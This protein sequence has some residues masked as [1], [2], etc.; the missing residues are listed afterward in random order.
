MTDS[1]VSA[2]AAAAAALRVHRFANGVT[3]ILWPEPR[4]TVV[5]VQIWVGT[6]SADEVAG[7][8]G[9]AHMLEHLMFRGTSNVPDGE[10]DRRMEALGASINAATWL[11]YTAYTATAPPEALAGILALEAD[12]FDGLSLSPAVFTA[13]RSVV[14]NE[15][16]QVVEADPIARLH[17]TLFARTL[18]GSNYA[19]PTIGFSED[20]AGYEL[21]DVI[22]FHRRHYAPSRLAVVV[23][24][25]A[26][27]A[28][29]LEAIDTTFGALAHRDAPPRVFPSPSIAAC[30]EVVPL[31]VSSA[32]VSMAWQCPPRLDARHAAWT[33]FNEVLCGGESS[34][35]PARLEMNDRSV[36]DVSS[37]LGAHA[38][39]AMFNVEATLRARVKPA[40]VVAAIDEEIARLASDGPTERELN[41]ARMRMRTQDATALA[42]TSSRADWA[43]ESWVV[44]GDPL[45]SFRLADAVAAL[46][47]DDVRA[48]A[49]EIANAPRVV[50]KAMPESA[51]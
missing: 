42:T 5:S 23:C 46:N 29:M 4:D 3:A 7:K 9:L 18:G 43:G 11:D 28:A 44:S 40:T 49:R 51:A 13:E 17:E 31:P 26:S 19:W 22:A 21:D 14:A 25:C 39:I 41:A 6:G 37:Q 34:R 33:L 8:T 27:E 50:L 32:R 47:I 16:R 45:Q 36:L 12:R 24:G 2:Y 35:L 1:T 15:R 48:V 10:F 20:I 30:D 38:Q